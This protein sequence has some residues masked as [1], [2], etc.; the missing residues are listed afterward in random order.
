MHLM[1]LD[2]RLVISVSIDTLF[3][4]FIFSF[5]VFCFLF[6]LLLGVD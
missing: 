2:V 6:I 4:A 1:L 3:L 5:N